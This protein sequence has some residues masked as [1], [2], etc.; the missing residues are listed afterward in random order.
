MNLV[1]NDLAQRNP[2]CPLA[3]VSEIH[4]AGAAANLA[5]Y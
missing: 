5:T 3:L 1:F 2:T 4:G